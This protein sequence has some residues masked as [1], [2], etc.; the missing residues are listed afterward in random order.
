MITR[1]G[2]QIGSLFVH[3]YGIILMLGAL[4]AAW[5]TTREAKRRGIDSEIVW[6]M[7]PWLLVAGIIGSRLWHVFTPPASMEALGYTRNF[8]FEHPLEI[9]MIWKGGL[10][11][12]GAVIGGALALWI[13]CRVKK[14]SFL[15]W[16]DIIAPGL[17]LAQAIGRWGNFVNQELYGQPSSLP[18]AIYIDQ[19]RRLP[20]FERI[21]YYHP[22]FLYESLWN[23]LNMG[24]LLWL[25]RK[26][27]DTLKL[28]DLFLVYLIVYPVGRFAL[29][30][31]RLDPSNVGG[32]NIN[33][34]VMAVTA[35]TAA[36]ILVLRHVL[37]K[38]KA[39]VEVVEDAE[40]T[41]SDEAPVE[42]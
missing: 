8:Y 22:L 30:F 12:P 9:L 31:L 33:Q 15:A 11:I 18:W 19:N 35:L 20:G 17:A 42:E 26:F 3:F 37:G 38:N 34:T 13:Y 32:I 24:L 2:I 40:I 39:A 25:G 16:T 41:A 27:K 23:L 10:G 5:L 6:D 36:V 21:P 28:G 7:L 14:I 1:E 4:V 29:E